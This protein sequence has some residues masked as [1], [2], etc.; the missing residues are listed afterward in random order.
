M[1]AAR[2]LEQMDRVAEQRL[3]D[4]DYAAK[5]NSHLHPIFQGICAAILATPQPQPQPAPSVE[6]VSLYHLMLGTHEF[7]GPEDVGQFRAW[8]A[9]DQ[10]LRALQV[11]VDPDRSIWRQYQPDEVP[12]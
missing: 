9:R 1:R 3:R 10:A 11:E 7:V 4:A 8:L 2:E 12:A 6:R 5:G